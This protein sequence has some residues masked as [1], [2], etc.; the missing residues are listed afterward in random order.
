MPTARRYFHLAASPL[1]STQSIPAA[2]FTDDLGAAITGL[3][4]A[5][6]SGYTHLFINGVLQESR[7][8]SLSPEGMTLYLDGDVILQGTPIIVEIVQFALAP[9]S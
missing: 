2:S 1:T 3:P 5:G 8:Y 4:E 6:P 7:L 9:L